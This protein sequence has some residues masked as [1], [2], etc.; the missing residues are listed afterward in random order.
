MM[1]EQKA[2]IDLSREVFGDKTAE[3]L[4]ARF[5]VQGSIITEG[6]RRSVLDSARRTAEVVSACRPRG[7]PQ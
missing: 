4:A 6:F 7:E 1:E 2:L 5:E 3:E